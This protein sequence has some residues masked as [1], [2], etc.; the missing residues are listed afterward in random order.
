MLKKFVLILL[1]IEVFFIN[2]CV[3][4]SKGE[5]IPSDE[6]VLI[7]K[8]STPIENTFP[9]QISPTVTIITQVT[10]VIQNVTK[11]V[12]KSTYKIDNEKVSQIIKKLKENQKGRVAMYANVIIKTI[13]AKQSPQV[14]KG[15]VIIKKNDKFRIRYTEP[16]EQLIISNGKT[17]WIYTPEL[18]Q[19]IKQ[20]AE[21]SQM[22]TN[23]YVE[24]ESS[25]EY[26]VNQSKTYI[27][28]DEKNYTL[29]MYPK[30]KKVI[31]FDKLLVK[32]NKE[33]MVPEY[34]GMVYQS[35]TTHVYF[36]NVRNYSSQQALNIKELNDESFEFVVPEGVEEIDASLLSDIK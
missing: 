12:K 7:K 4:D 13:Y 36:N 16:T 8:D 30:D 21:E 18:K 9:E 2:N 25:I 32:I 11:T 5:N 10:A 20:S 26:Y 22:G 3:S 29:V 19:V 35:T 23:F 27:S 6:V 28:E 31:N 24:L 34:M 33:K 14:V 1:I 15:R 17:I